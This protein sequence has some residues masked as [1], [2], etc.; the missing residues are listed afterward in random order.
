MSITSNAHACG[1]D[2]HVA[3]E[4]LP[5]DQQREHDDQPRHRLA[6]E[7][8]HL[9]DEQHQ[10]LHGACP[11]S[12]V[13]KISHPARAPANRPLRRMAD[14]CCSTTKRHATASSATKAPSAGSGLLLRSRLRAEVVVHRDAEVVVGVVLPLR[15]A[16]G[17]GA[18][19]R[20]DLL[21]HRHLGFLLGDDRRPRSS[22]GR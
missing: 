17:E 19:R 3:R 7:R 14:G 20:V 15:R 4:H 6:H 22:A 21:E 18:H 13:Q 8:A 10:L 11:D 9:V 2:E 12:S 16:L 1:V 5:R